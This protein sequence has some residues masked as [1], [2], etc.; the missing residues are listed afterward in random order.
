MKIIQKMQFNTLY[1]GNLAL[2]QTSKTAKNMEVILL[3]HFAKDTSLRESM[4][5]ERFCVKIG[6][7]KCCGRRPHFPIGE[8][9]KQARSFPGV[10]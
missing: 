7:W 2:L 6:C 10:Y 8:P 1:N 5:F 3:E 9:V 4:S